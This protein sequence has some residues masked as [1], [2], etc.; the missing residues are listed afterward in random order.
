[1]AESL[2]GRVRLGGFEINLRSGE[3]RAGRGGKR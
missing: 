3:L 2:E 1:M